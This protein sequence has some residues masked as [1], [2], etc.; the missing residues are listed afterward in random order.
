M[1]GLWLRGRLSPVTCLPGTGRLGYREQAASLA[2]GA[3]DTYLRDEPRDFLAVATPGAGKTAYALRVATELLSR[4]IV[5]RVTVVT[6]T[7]HLKTSGRTR[8]RVG[9]ALD[10]KFR[11][12]VGATSS[13]YHGIAVTYAGVAR[14]PAAPRPHGDPAHA[15]DPRRGPP[16]GRQHDRGARGAARRSSR[17]RAA[18]R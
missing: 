11:N 10:P 8:R 13:D 9:I 4:G 18:S 1:G 3:L 15:G 6:P 2:A 12:S 5:H 17:R 16:R 7:E 14:A